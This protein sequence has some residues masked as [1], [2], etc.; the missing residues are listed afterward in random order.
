M[1]LL[2]FQ[3][4]IY[5]NGQAMGPDEGCSVGGCIGGLAI[6]LR[7]NGPTGGHAPLTEHIAQILGGV[8]GGG[9][10]CS[11]PLSLIAPSR[12]GNT[13]VHRSPSVLALAQPIRNL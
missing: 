11:S 4:G 8:A 5:D 7:T 3:S 12:R 13:V 6:S 10:L 1:R 9:V 2:S